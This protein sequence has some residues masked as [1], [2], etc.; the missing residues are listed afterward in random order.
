M[1]Y[2]EYSF[3]VLTH[4]AKQLRRAFSSCWTICV[5]PPQNRIYTRASNYLDQIIIKSTQ[6]TPAIVVR[7][8]AA[9]IYKKKK[10]TKYK[11]EI[12]K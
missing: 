4:R 2:S 10:S 8:S 3:R 6:I 11:S 12:E 1:S 5:S 7:F 9:P